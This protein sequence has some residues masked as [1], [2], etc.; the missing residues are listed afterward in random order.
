MCTS[1]KRIPLSAVPLLLEDVYESLFSVTLTSNDKAAQF[2][3][4]QE[5]PCCAQRPFANG[6]LVCSV[7]HLH[8]GGRIQW[9]DALLASGFLTLKGVQK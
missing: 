2:T 9:T 5:F 6:S 3:R 7:R 8:I 1:C 4:C